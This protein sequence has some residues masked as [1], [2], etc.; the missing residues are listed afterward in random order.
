MFEL[1]SWNPGA[2]T[3]TS[4]RSPAL[5]RGGMTAAGQPAAVEAGLAMLRAGGRAADAAVA[6]A[7]VLAVVEPCSTGL[8]GDAFALVLDA[9]TGEV[10][11]LNGSGRSAAALD[12]AAARGRGCTGEALPARS[13]LA[14][15]APGS[16]AAWCDLLE[17]FGRLPLAQVLEPARRL[18]EEGFAVHPV[19]AATWAA[20]EAV[21]R[22]APGGGELLPGGRAPRPGQV[23][24]NPGLARVLGRLGAAGTAGAR[25]LFYRGDIAAAVARAV[26]EAGGL[27]A[28]SDLAAHT[29]QWTTPLGADY[30]GIRILE[31]PPN[32][33]GVTV[34]LALNVL[35]RLD[36]ALLG[37]PGSAARVHAQVEALRLAFADARAWVADPDAAPAPLAELLSADYASRRAALVRPDRA[38]PAAAAGLPRPAPGTV[39]FVVV[40]G[41]GNACSMVN[42]NYMG[43]GT[44]IVPPGLGFSLHNRGCNFRLEEGHPNCLAPGR[45]P[46]HTIIPGL[47]LR[48]DGSLYAAFGVMGAFM[49]PQG[50]VQVLSALLDDGADPQA[51]LDAPR[52]CLE[53]A[54]GGTLA[55]EPA[56]PGDLARSL[57]DRGHRVRTTGP[58]ETALFGRGQIIVRSRDGVLCGGSDPRAD[59][60]ALGLG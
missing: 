43:F 39:Q 14:V 26:Q 19:A 36:P 51:A 27:L 28:E 15:T 25:D 32:G 24:R 58:E 53:S 34:L 7:A 55:L 46:Y 40:D 45:R 50:Q 13:A 41:A 10:A 49:Q 33:Q 47:A 60:C 5:A 2:L 30:R 8:G 56:M 38:L 21:L 18:A 3:F 54:G 9:A 17:R 42:S 57:A 31:C 52:F 11:A 16:C 29:S 37:A 4:R 22:A 44:G 23:V 35:S 59:G 12:L 20:G 6:M 48:P 1:S